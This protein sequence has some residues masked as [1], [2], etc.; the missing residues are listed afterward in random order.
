MKLAITHT[1]LYDYSNDVRLEPHYLYLH[2]KQGPYLKVDQYSLQISPTPDFISKNV[3]SAD[4]IQHIVF[5]NNST[6]HLSIKA[7]SI[8]EV[9]EFNPYS[10]IYHPFESS[11]LPIKYANDLND[12]L[13][14][15]LNRKGVTTYVDQTARQI[16]A[17]VNWDTSSFLSELNKFIH[18]FAYEIREEGDAY[19]PEKTLLERRG[20]CRDYS[21][22]FMAMCRALGI[23]SK[24]VSGYYFSDPN[25]PQYLHAWVNVYLPGGGWR[26]YDPT[27]NCLVS[28]RHIPLATSAMP[29]LISPIHGTFRGS[30]QSVFKAEVSVR[31]IEE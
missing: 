22:L 29:N 2:P 24:F 19:S 16:A 28:G 3:D 27:Q 1:L 21:V 12:S 11:R 17:S 7:E 25:Q 23:A 30:A 5:F 4:N 26:G 10:F 9:T 15:Y 6:R 31:K 8:I 18:S 13:Q 14:S 20:S